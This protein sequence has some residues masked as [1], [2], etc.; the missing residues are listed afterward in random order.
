MILNVIKWALN[1][2]TRFI[3]NLLNKF[4]KETKKVD[5]I[6]SGMNTIASAAIL[7]C[8]VLLFGWPSIILLVFL[9]VLVDDITTDITKT[10]LS[11]V[12]D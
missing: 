7:F 8:I 11:N 5:V 4:A 2:P 3:N 6:S 10:A 12:T 1:L 9:T